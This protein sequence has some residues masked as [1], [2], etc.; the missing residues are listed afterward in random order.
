MKRILTPL[1][2][3]KLTV[4]LLA[5]AMLLVYVGTGAQM[6]SGIVDV[7]HK[8]FH[9]LFCWI[10]FSTLLLQRAE[11]G[12]KLVAGGFPM[13]GGYAIGLML[14]INL[15]AAHSV[16]FSLT[17][18]R[19]GIIL[20]HF[21]LILLLVGE[22]ITSV[23]QV[24]SRMPLAIGD[25]ANWTTDIRSY[26]LAITD[27]GNRDHDK[28]TSIRPALLKQGQAIHD[29]RLPF[30]VKIDEWDENSA[31][32]SPQKAPVVAAKYAKATA[33]QGVGYGLIPQPSRTGVG[34]DASSPN[35]P[36]AYVT[37]TKGDKTLGTFLVSTLIGQDPEI[38]DLGTQTVEVDG[39][40]YEMALRFTRIYKPYTVRLLNF[41]HKLYTGTDIARDFASTIRLT[42]P[43]RGV[44]REI[45]V[46]M[47]H[48]LRYQGETFY[49]SGFGEGDQSSTLQVVSNPGWLM[50]YFAC[51]IGALGLVIHFGMT[52][53]KFLRKRAI[54]NSQA[55]AP[56][57]PA[58]L[59]EK[60]RRERPLIVVEPESPWTD[61]A[62]PVGAVFLAAIYVLTNAMTPKNDGPFDVASWARLPDSF[63]GRVQP[64]DSVARNGL[65]I[66]SGRETFYPE[67]TSKK[68]GHARPAAEWLIQVMND[69]VAAAN[70]KV[71]RIDAPDVKSMFTDDS[72]QEYFAPSEIFAQWHKFI[73]QMLRAQGM[74]ADGKMA[75]KDD[76]YARNLGTVWEKI[77]LYVVLGGEQNAARL[78]TIHVTDAA[79]KAKLELPAG[80]TQFSFADIV[81]H[82]QSL[83]KDLPEA[84]DANPATRTPY[85]TA[86]VDMAND[87]ELSEKV[88]QQ[89]FK[90][91]QKSG[92]LHPIPPASAAADWATVIEASSVAESNGGKPPFGLQQWQQLREA[93]SAKQPGEFNETV[94]TYAA[95]LEHRLPEEMD[96]ARFE[97]KFNQFAPFY[98]AMVLYIIAFVLV[99]VSWIVWQKPL[100]R[101]AV[102]LVALAFAIHTGGLMARIYIS[103]RPPVTNLASSAIFIAWGIVVLAAGLERVFRNS[104]GL[105]TA[106]AAGF[107]SLLIADRLALEGDTMKVL[108]AVL[109]TNYWLATHVVCITLGYAATFL[110]GVL[111]IVYIFR[112]FI[113]SSFDKDQSRELARMIYGI[114][115]FGMFF[116]LVGTILGGIWADQSWGR[117]WGW[118]PK[119]NGAVL[120]V[121]GNALL[122]HARWGGVIRDRGI[123]LFAIF[124]NIVT[125]WSWFGTNMLG[126]GLH[127]YGFMPS[128]LKVLLAFDIS[129]VI[130]IGIGLI[131]MR[132][133]ANAR[134]GGD[135]SSGEITAPVN[136]R[137]S[138]ATA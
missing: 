37:L 12:K 100:Y 95:S 125:A 68:A 130:L 78:P 45:R 49:Q 17:W 124:G 22:A 38:A 43:S 75:S 3:L 27:P 18:K 94:A 105:L 53:F 118:D 30:D 32:M 21:G 81:E 1:A 31:I 109:D 115:C 108:V 65:K 91:A 5:L 134:N 129:Q 9:S 40:P 48:P 50:P 24:E 73:E 79:L 86:L 126:V 104:I 135:D 106:S 16:R 132:F 110:A 97:A 41:E 34:E 112:A 127:S 66:L 58:K 6:N 119:E 39:K 103:G 62:I 57:V 69:P 14:L 122:L 64:L 111:G 107:A 128:A 123:A 54:L 121:L 42:D 120:I 29:A 35:F 70:Y 98:Q 60:G 63:E 85:Q 56:S 72:M 80:Q 87:V 7:Q 28:V 88:S 15:L 13:L 4:V 71:I 61:W 33:G 10:N 2:S 47:N 113:D 96:K 26:E 11:P 99:C 8:Y 46:W 83:Q 114:V 136:K 92:R 74:G 55:T 138:V 19:S 20:I 76:D 137:V 116:S 133:W 25:A 101:T 77:K 131:P 59:N 90:D 51:A 36:S 102:A 44:D 93:Y 52:L 82:A 84:L 23:F 117:F 67:R 89:I